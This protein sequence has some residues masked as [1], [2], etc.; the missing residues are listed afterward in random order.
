MLNPW[1]YEI[2]EDKSH[3]ALFL[4]NKICCCIAWQI[5]DIPCRHAIRAMV[6]VKL[7]PIMLLAHDILLGHKNI[8]IVLAIIPYLIRINGLSMMIHLLSYR[9]QLRGGWETMQKQEKREEG[10]NQKGK[11][12]TLSNALNVTSLAIMQ[13]L[14]REDWLQ[15][16]KKSKRRWTNSS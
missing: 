10:E 8:P 5:S 12:A 15:K 1:E 11:S 9:L 4:N 14:V 7:I 13:E 2:H 3:F 6:H 16:K